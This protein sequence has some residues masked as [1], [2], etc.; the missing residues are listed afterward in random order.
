MEGGKIRQPPIIWW[1]MGDLAERLGFP[2]VQVSPGLQ[3]GMLTA[4]AVSPS[5]WSVCS[6]CADVKCKSH[7]SVGAEVSPQMLWVRCT[8]ERASTSQDSK[9]QHCRYSCEQD[10]SEN[11]GVPPSSQRALQGV[12]LLSSHTDSLLPSFS[13]CSLTA[14]FALLCYQMPS[15]SLPRLCFCPLL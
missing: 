14:L 8:C 2:A 15:C 11:F 10:T 13:L 3:Y 1:N 9:P 7:C 12:G 5:G 4:L 6:H